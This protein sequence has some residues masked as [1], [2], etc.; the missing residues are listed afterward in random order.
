MC[1]YQHRSMHL[2]SPSA[3]QAASGR[4]PRCAPQPCA[5]PACLP[6]APT[7][8]AVTPELW[9]CRSCS[10]AKLPASPGTPPK[11]S[12]RSAILSPPAHAGAQDFHL[13]IRVHTA[14]DHPQFRGRNG[15]CLSSQPGGAWAGLRVRRCIWGSTR[16][17]GHVG[18]QPGPS[19]WPSLLA[20]LRSC[21]FAQLPPCMRMPQPRDEAEPHPAPRNLLVLPAGL[22][23]AP[24]AVLLAAARHHQPL[25]RHALRHEPGEGP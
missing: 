22:P 15:A 3:R 7:A 25:L 13:G 24:P 8:I 4:A 18:L 17:P 10:T 12:R 20:W 16:R 14:D 19:T 21:A 11:V 5:L 23:R 9:R 2:A 6:A 1:P